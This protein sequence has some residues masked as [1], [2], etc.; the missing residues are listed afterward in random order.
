M[1]KITLILFLTAKFIS[2]GKFGE[3]NI[4]YG[5]PA[6]VRGSWSKH[7]ISWKS[8][9]L[10]EN[11]GT[12]QSTFRD[13]GIMQVSSD[14]K[15]LFKKSIIQM[16]IDNNLGDLIH[17]GGEETFDP[18][19]LNDIQ[20]VL[21]DGPFLDKGDIFLSL[22]NL[23]MIILYRPT[24]NKVLWYQQGPWIYQ[25]DV[26]ILGN[27]E[28]SI[29]NDNLNLEKNKVNGNNNTLIYDF[30]SK[31]TFNPYKKAY[32][33]NKIATPEAGLSEILNNNDIF[34]EETLNG[35][36]L[37]MDKNGKIIWKYINRSSNKKLYI[38]S[39]TRYLSNKIVTKKLQVNFY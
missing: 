38:L 17:G 14:G 30:S 7:Y 11:L 18:I 21:V 10:D 36:L 6:E 19:H 29:F 34:V 37:R 1:R 8:F 33:I 13:D 5:L 16:F 15:I 23:S 28:I 27:N 39:W 3:T 35:R 9:R 2:Y 22:R 20:P 31:K 12:N 32:E 25:H 4:I 26:D 24:T